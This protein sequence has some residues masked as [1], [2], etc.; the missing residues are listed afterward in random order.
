MKY[1]ILILAH[2]LIAFSYAMA[3]DCDYKSNSFKKAFNNSEV[4]VSGKVIQENL[5]VPL[6]V[7]DDSDKNSRS[8]IKRMANEFIVLV[9]SVYKGD[10][11]SDTI[12]VR[13]GIG[14]SACGIVLEVG[15]RY[16]IYSHNITSDSSYYRLSELSAIY[17]SICSRTKLY[18]GIESMRL[19]SKRRRNR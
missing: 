2:I 5:N 18:T 8:S 11:K 13:T 16:T 14:S 3:C 19:K 7:G 9:E 15:K 4:I 12:I 17:S 1:G 10:V 6:M